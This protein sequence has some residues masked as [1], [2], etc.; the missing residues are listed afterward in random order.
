MQFKP[1]TAAI[2]ASATFP[3]TD[4]VIRE[5]QK[6]TVSG[7]SADVRRHPHGVRSSPVAT[8]RRWSY[9]C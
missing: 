6:S 5:R 3:A 8:D 4:E 1:V 7:P 9:S 2:P